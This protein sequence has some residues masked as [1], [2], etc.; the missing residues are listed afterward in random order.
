MKK[1]TVVLF[2]IIFTTLIIGS[3]QYVSADHLLLDGKGIFKNEDTANK[4]STK[5]SKYQLH[6]QVVVRNAGGQLI[7]IAEANYG[8]FIPHEI[9]DHTFNEKLGEREI[10]TIDN[11]KYEKI[12]YAD[13]LDTRQLMGDV[14]RTSHVA[15]LWMI[16]LCGEVDEHGHSCLPIFQANTPQV[17]ITQ[18]DVV[19]NQWTILREMN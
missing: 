13:I 7:S 9:T 19:I 8:V 1:L 6:V 10:I 2:S 14:S 16:Q 4:S 3:I 5:D 11:I 15:G 12:Q 17:S 18:E